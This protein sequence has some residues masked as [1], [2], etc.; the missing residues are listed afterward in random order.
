[1]HF[2]CA[3]KR[4]E[5]N[6]LFAGDLYAA[7]STQVWKKQEACVEQIP[8]LCGANST[9]KPANSGYFFARF[10]VN[11]SIPHYLTSI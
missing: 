10:F 7:C 3:W 6:N 9:Q 8:Y 1:M 4:Q 2:S 11:I 5:T